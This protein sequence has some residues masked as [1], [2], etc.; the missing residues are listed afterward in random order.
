L[1]GP[2]V[3]YVVVF[4]RKNDSRQM[5]W[6]RITLYQPEHTL[7]AVLSVG[8]SRSARIWI[9]SSKGSSEM[10]SILMMAVSSRSRPLSTSTSESTSSPGTYVSISELVKAIP[11]PLS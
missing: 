2:L 11:I 1:T 7:L 4:S 9:A 6:F 5:C 8:A 3:A 10:K